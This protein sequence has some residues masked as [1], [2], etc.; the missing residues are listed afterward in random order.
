MLLCMF[1]A[2]AAPSSGESEVLANPPRGVQLREEISSIVLGT[3]EREGRRVVNLD[4][5]NGAERAVHFAW[6]VEWMDKTGAVLSG[7]PIGWRPMHLE[8]G[9]TAPI[10]IEAPHPRAASWRLIAIDMAL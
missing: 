5:K 3:S 6:A 7:T 4:L 1:A 2:C 9:A 10:E 8:P